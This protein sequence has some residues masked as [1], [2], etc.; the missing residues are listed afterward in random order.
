MSD[1]DF[2]TE[3]SALTIPNWC[4]YNPHGIRI[5]LVMPFE[6]GFAIPGRYEGGGSALYGG[7]LRLLKFMKLENAQQYVQM[8]NPCTAIRWEREEIPQEEAVR[9]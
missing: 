2:Y 7:G 1:H 4:A 5:S 9:R 6:D 3:Q 8:K